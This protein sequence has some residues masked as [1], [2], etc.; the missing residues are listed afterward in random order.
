MAEKLIGQDIAPPDLVAKITGRAKYAEDFRPEGMVF[1]K[2]LLSPMPHARVKSIDASKARALPGFLGILTADELP[3]EVNPPNERPLTNEPL[4]VGEPILAVAAVDET[5]AAQAVELIDVDLEPL[6]F[7]LDPLESLKPDGP[8]ARLEGNV[9]VRRDN[10]NV[11]ET[12]KWPQEIFDAAP[13]PDDLPMGDPINEWTVGDLD[14]GFTAADLVLEEVVMAQSMTHHPLETRTTA[15]YWDNGKCYVYGSTQSHIRTKVGL[16][17][18][19]GLEPDDLVFIGEYCGGG[20]GSKI[21]GSPSMQIPAVFSRK[22]GRPVMMRITRY[23]ENYIG[24]GRPAFQA[25]TKIGWRN[26]G[27]VTAIDLY[28][29]QDHGPYGSAGDHRSAADMASLTYQP[30][31]MR[32][33]G[34]S[35]YTNTPPRAA[36]RA[37]GGAQIVAM[38]EPIMDKAA[39]ELGVD[40]LEMRRIN[41]PNSS[42]TFGAGERGLTGAFVREAIDAGKREFDWDAKIQLSGRRTGTKVTGVGIG[43]SPYTA[44]S[45]GFDGLLVIRPDGKVYIHQGIGNLGTHSIADTARAAADVLGVSW[46]QVSVVWGDSSKHLPWSSVQAGSQ[47]T[48]AHTRAN[49]AA[50]MDAKRK[51]QEI[52]AREFGGAPADF[53]TADGRVFKRSNAAQSMTFARAAQQAIAM[54]GKYSGESLPDDINDTTR[55]SASALAGE[56]L[57]G[58]AKDNYGRDGATQSWVVGF[59]TVELDV[60]TGHVDITEYVAS[61]DCGV[62]VHPRSLAAQMYGGGIQ[63]FGM[64]RS[65]RWVFDPVWGVPFAHRLYTARPP[66]MLD[67]P[68][69]MGWAAA[70][71]PDPDSPVGAKGIGEPPLG[72]G[73]AAITSA[74]ADALG[75]ECLC[76]MPLTTDVILAELEGRDQPYSKLDTHV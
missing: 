15:A 31:A 19:L 9:R 16:A 18:Q 50:G 75:G 56:G 12:M 66:G 4:Y 54:G 41:A 35:A 51:L 45:V 61:A 22:I 65:Q 20:F 70:N 36:Q 73:A 33:R 46:N 57:M 55:H 21:A 59:A 28:I 72:A 6:P 34:I 49:H 60:E 13:G 42:S 29:V 17:R 58:V 26:D 5:T 62:V 3:G 38:L 14:A 37:P 7:V 47:T 30:T 52:A 2:L 48:Y 53:D 64:A 32:F 44:G 43:L 40:R 27:K 1:A 39:R 67:V 25:W 11:L 74:I 23:E 76:R 71:V 69:N 8:N 68:L 24:R 10:E 63:G